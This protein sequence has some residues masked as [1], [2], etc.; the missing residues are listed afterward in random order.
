MINLFSN[1]I[2][3]E[4]ESCHVP[5]Y[6]GENL[7][8]KIKAHETKKIYSLWHKWHNVFEPADQGDHD[9]SQCFELVP[10]VPSPVDNR[11][12][13]KSMHT[14]EGKDLVVQGLK[15]GSTFY[16]HPG[17]SIVAVPENKPRT[18]GGAGIDAFESIKWDI[19]F[20]RFE[21]DLDCDH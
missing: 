1:I 19:N 4:L 3:V 16:R 2:L 20:Y 7:L 8:V 12:M 6:S 18:D 10:V 5:N 11:F 15:V 17:N 9:Q 21:F 13:I 14:G